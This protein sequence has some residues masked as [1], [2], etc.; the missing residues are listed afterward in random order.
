ML[1]REKVTSTVLVLQFFLFAY[2]FLDFSHLQRGKQLFLKQ[3]IIEKKILQK[4]I[5]ISDTRDLGKEK[6][7]L[8]ISIIIFLLLDY[9]LYT[10]C[11]FFLIIITQFLL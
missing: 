7:R 8:M 3:I 5:K 6:F 11:F 9:M 10:S 4:I 1:D 2:F